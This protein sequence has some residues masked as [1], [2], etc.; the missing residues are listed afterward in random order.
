MKKILAIFGTRPEA[1]K[2]CP[3]IL[4]LKKNDK[5]E[6][7]VCL[8]GQH[9][10][11][12]QQIMKCF[13]IEVDYNLHIMK[14]NQSLSDITIAILESLEQ[15]LKIEHP[16]LVLVHGDTTTSFAAALQSFYLKIDVGH[17]EAGLRTGNKDLPYPEEMNRLMTDRISTYHFAPTELNKRNLIKENI[18][19]NIYV[20]G[21][22]VIDSF[23]TT[24]KENY[25]FHEDK[26]NSVNYK[27]YK[28]I[29]MTAHRR[30][31]WGKALAE[32]CDAIKE[33][34]TNNDDTW[35]IYPVHLNPNVRKTVFTSLNNF[36]RIS[37]IEPI[38]VFDMH[39]LLNRCY[40]VM[41]DSGGLQ[42]EAPF[43]GKPVLVLRT[44]TERPEAI[45]A[46]AAQLAGIR[47]NKIVQ[48]ANDLLRNKEI[49]SKMQKNRSL[50]G[51]GN[52]SKII[53]NILQEKLLNEQK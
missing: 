17:V 48:A 52:A 9:E 24:I 43:L 20:T 6:T 23:S 53:A 41:T 29:L 31:N 18:V 22:T 32:I 45:E 14:K 26:L 12:L 21:N 42:E 37:L 38:D 51:D 30:E 39:N 46:G 36:E 2:M 10:S 11:M 19:D 5:I 4:E 33:I 50:Y 1:I 49:Y 40:M 3:L 15:V 16:D 28:I 13:Q 34:I 8:T 7:K 47:K 25:V 44:E 27:K 35:V